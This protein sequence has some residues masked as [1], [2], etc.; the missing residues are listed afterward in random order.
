MKTEHIL[1]MRFSALGD[2]A[3]LVPVVSSLARQYPAVR[4]TVLSRPFARALFE[5]LA[6]NVGFMEADLKGEYS[7][8]KGLNALYRRLVAKNFTAVADMHNIL[9]SGYLRMRFNPRRYRVEHQ[10][11]PAGAAAAHRLVGGNSCASCPHRSRT[12]P[13]CSNASATPCSSASH[14]SSPR[15]EAT[16]ACSPRR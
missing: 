7:G 8:M 2:V 9:R 15:Q 6:P 12:T 16:C 13:T 11:A 4:V 1:I 3:M 10:Q 5:G 14:R